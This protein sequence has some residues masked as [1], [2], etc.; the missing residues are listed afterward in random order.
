MLYIFRSFNQ[1]F[2]FSHRGSVMLCDTCMFRQQY[3]Q[4]QQQKQQN[5]NKRNGSKQKLKIKEEK[6]HTRKQICTEILYQ[7]NNTEIKMKKVQLFFFSSLLKTALKVFKLANVCVWIFSFVLI[8]L[9]TFFLFNFLV[10]CLHCW[11][12]VAGWLPA[13][14]QCFWEFLWT[15]LVILYEFKIHNHIQLHT[16]SFSL[17]LSIYASM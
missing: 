1:S 7:P 17:F 13:S 8:F 3:Q 4:Q 10:F 14:L 2:S 12:L 9:F 15:C 11:L 6:C 5:V 16:L